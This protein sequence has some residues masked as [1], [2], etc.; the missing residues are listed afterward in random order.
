MGVKDN[1]ELARRDWMNSAQF[2]RLQDQDFWAKRWADA[3][4]EFAH[5]GMQD[6]LHSLGWSCLPTVGWAERG[7]ISSSGH[8]NSVPRFHVTWGTGPRIVELFEIPVKEA[9]KK[10]LVEFKFRHRV[11][12]I[13]KDDTGRAIGVK[14]TVLQ[15]DNSDRGVASNREPVGTF[16][17][18][19]RAILISTGG[20]GGN[21]ALV[22]ENWPAS[23]LGG[24]VPEFFVNGVPAHVDGRML[25]VAESAGACLVNKDRGWHYTE[26]MINWD[27]IWPSHGIRIIPGPSPIWLNARGERMAPPAIP[28]CDTLATLKQI[29]STGCDYSW[30]VL[31]ET[32]M[33]KEFMLSGS[34]QNPD[35]TS[36]S[37]WGVLKRTLSGQ[38]PVR[39]FKE[40]GVDFVVAE[41]V[42]ELVAGMNKLRRGNAPELDPESVEAIIKDRD[43]QIDN[44]FTKD[45]Q[46]MVIQNALKFRGDRISRCAPLHKILDPK[47]RPLIA[48]RMN[49]LT[50]KTLG[51]IQTNL[52]SQ[53]MRPDGSVFPGLYSAGE[54]A[55]F[56]GGGLHG[57]NAL[58]GTF[59]TG[60]IFSGRAAGIAMAKDGVPR[61]ER[62]VL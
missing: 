38:E 13:L 35:L 33:M 45:A 54:V 37:L 52:E 47:H 7:A 30:F 27:P 29:L 19:G 23:R 59:L 34:E 8:G 18:R 16:E 24:Y 31:N 60:C 5:K 61:K 49:I 50:R 44:P 39:K 36:K 57:Y 17:L 2:D 41:S 22:K 53:V 20:I 58:E 48:V 12:E 1:V 40:H 26:G 46:I 15:E 25:K 6:Y 51:G 9:A 4:V 55:G 14:G 11:D 56:G 62:S 21:P 3:Y 32:I 10:G 42:G 43:D 28:G